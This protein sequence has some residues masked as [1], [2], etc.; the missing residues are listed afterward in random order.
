M[1]DD[2]AV[3]VVALVVVVLLMAEMLMGRPRSLPGMPQR[4]PTGLL[5]SRS[6][7]E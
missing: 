1:L 2:E 3:L 5:S 7:C 4:R 6:V